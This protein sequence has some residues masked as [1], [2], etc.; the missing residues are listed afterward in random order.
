MRFNHYLV[1]H[2]TRAGPKKLAGKTIRAIIGPHAGLAY[3]GPTV[4][5]QAV[6]SKF[7]NDKISCFNSLN[8]CRI[9]GHAY[10]EIDASKLDREFLLGPSHHF[11]LKN[12]GL[13]RAK[14]YQTP[15][16]NL[17]LDRAVIDDLKSTD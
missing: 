10:K 9:S 16:H 8:R 17:N 3:S 12:C 7:C 11:Y 1:F 13:S 5:F 6:L 4:S 2:L 15:I 14:I